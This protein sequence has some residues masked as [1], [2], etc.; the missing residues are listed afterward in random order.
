[1]SGGNNRPRE[2]SRNKAQK[3]RDNII[4]TLHNMEA[5]EDVIAGEPGTKASRELEA[6]NVRRAE[7]LPSMVREMKEE[8]ARKELDREE[9]SGRA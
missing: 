3:I 4:S 5:A 7:A 9:Q 6:K 2:D 1:M 8:E